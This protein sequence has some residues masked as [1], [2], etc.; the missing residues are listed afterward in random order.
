MDGEG[1]GQDRGDA[2][3]SC[4]DDKGVVGQGANI[5]ASEA[6]GWRRGMLG[7][8]WGADGA[9]VAIKTEQKWNV[10][11][12]VMVGE[13]GGK[14]GCEFLL[15]TSSGEEVGL[16][17]RRSCRTA[18]K[19]ASRDHGYVTSPDGSCVMFALSGTGQARSSPSAFGRVRVAGPSHA[20]KREGFQAHFKT[21]NGLWSALA[22]VLWSTRNGR[23]RCGA[24]E[25]EDWSSKP[26]H[27]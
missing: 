4:N 25:S 20:E 13:R 6:D 1:L 9:Q 26:S 27:L 21:G 3:A 15:L 12:W 10:A 7:K 17:L 24:V 19:E 5:P 18:E 2:A 22:S 14:I 16:K 23:R 11:S 8:Y